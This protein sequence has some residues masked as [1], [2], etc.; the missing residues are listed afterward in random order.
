M[1]HDAGEDRAGRVRARSSRAAARS[2]TTL[3]I[4]CITLG[5]RKDSIV[6]LFGKISPNAVVLG[7]IMT[8]LRV[9]SRISPVRAACGRTID[10]LRALLRDR[11]GNVAVAA[12][13]TFVPLVAAI[14]LAIDYDRLSRGRDGVQRALDAATLAS[15]AKSQLDTAL[16]TNVFNA[17]IS[18]LGATVSNLAFTAVGDNINGTVTVTIPTTFAGIVATKTFDATLTSTAAMAPKTINSATFKSVSA[19]GAYS[20]DVF[21]FTRD[22]SGKIISQTTVL[23]YRYTYKYGTG[24]ATLSPAAG[25]TKTMTVGAYQTYGVGLV[26]YA[27]NSYTGKLINPVTKYSDASDAAQWIKSSG[28]CESSSGAT[29]NVEDGGDSDFA[30]F[31]YKFSCTLSSSS[32]DKARLTN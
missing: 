23:T 32:S 24:T 21:L 15:A 26:I 3:R 30:D 11:R 22:A 10:R 7:K 8:D 2:A 28:T 14:G 25:V 9:S 1:H 19:K 5:K 31:V 27:D 12:T 17:N 6:I 4:V 13:I 18:G 29:F 16:S 20:K